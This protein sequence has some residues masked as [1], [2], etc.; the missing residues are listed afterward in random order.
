[1]AAPVTTGV[2]AFVLSYFPKLT[3]VELKALLVSSVFETGKMKV[4]LPDPA[5]AGEKL[6]PFKKLSKSGGIVNAYNAAK[7]ALELYP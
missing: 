4:T 2:A 6:V 5:Y 3:A 7:M 1:M